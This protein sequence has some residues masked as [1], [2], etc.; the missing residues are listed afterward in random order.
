VSIKVE[1]TYDGIKIS[2]FF[3]CDCEKLHSVSGV[4]PSSKCECGLYLLDHMMVELMS[5]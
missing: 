5:Q 2:G 1:R 4:T 3:H